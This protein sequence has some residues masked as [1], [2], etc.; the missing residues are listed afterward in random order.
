MRGHV[1]RSFRRVP[2]ILLVF[3]DQLLEEVAQIERD[4]GVGIFL[5]HERAGCV[6]D[7]DGEQ[8]LAN[9]LFGDP[10][11]D[12]FGERIKTFAARGNGNG[13]ALDQS[14]F[15]LACLGGRSICTS[16]CRYR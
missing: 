7:K 9:I 15:R 3:G 12:R 11:L 4:I 1:V 16:A 14:V 5:N 8:P 10:I 6:L 13:R 2:I